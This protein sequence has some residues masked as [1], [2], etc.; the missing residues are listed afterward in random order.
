[1]DGLHCRSVTDLVFVRVYFVSCYSPRHLARS[2]MR[3]PS[4]PGVQLHISVPSLL[5]TRPWIP[6]NIWNLC[7]S[8]SSSSSSFATLGFIQHY[9]I[10]PFSNRLLA[11]LQVTLNCIEYL[12]FS[13]SLIF[14]HLFVSK[15]RF[16]SKRF[17]TLIF[18]NP[19]LSLDFYSKLG[20]LS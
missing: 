17:W 3:P 8:R 11:R 5:Q 16:L 1:M 10:L 14:F 7:L 19:L 13:L 4:F 9:C 12:E 15:V 6:F 2:W 20:I 18:L